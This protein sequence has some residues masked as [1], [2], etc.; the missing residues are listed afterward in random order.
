MSK[1]VRFRQPYPTLSYSNYFRLCGLARH[2]EELNEHRKRAVMLS[3]DKLAIEAPVERLK[4]YHDHADRIV[5]NRINLF[6]RR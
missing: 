1:V 4:L 6:R 2:V 5:R 3:S